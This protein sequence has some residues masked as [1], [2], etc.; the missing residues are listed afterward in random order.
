[1][2]HRVWQPRAGHLHV[3]G[4]VEGFKPCGCAVGCSLCMLAFFVHV[5]QWAAGQEI[6]QR[7]ALNQHCTGSGPEARLRLGPDD[8]QL[9]GDHLQLVGAQRVAPC[10]AAVADGRRAGR[11]HASRRQVLR[12]YVPCQ[13][14]VIK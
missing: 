10:Q 5:L 4:I 6:L 14:S 9:E 13:I 3:Q 7:M 11:Q 12:A 2:E 8:L 1:M